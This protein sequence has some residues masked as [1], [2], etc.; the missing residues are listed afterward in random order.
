MYFVLTFLT[1]FNIYFF[2]C[3]K[4]SWVK[5]RQQSILINCFWNTNKTNKAKK[6]PSI[7]FFKQW[8]DFLLFQLIFYVWLLLIYP[9]YSFRN[10]LSIFF[11]PV[12]FFWLESW[13][14][15]PIFFSLARC[16]HLYFLRLSRQS[17][18][19]FLHSGIF[20]FSPFIKSF[21]SFQLFLNLRSLTALHSS[22]RALSSY[23]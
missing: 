15:F 19:R 16:Y 6:K 8:T 20:S 18:C 17:I 2:F 4:T 10:L 9:S 1:L 21:I 12:D 3:K 13:F 14:C 11:L 23:L 22:N 5:T 7:F